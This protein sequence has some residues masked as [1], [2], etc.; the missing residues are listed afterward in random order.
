MTLGVCQPS[1]LLNTLLLSDTTDL[2]DY[3]TNLT[4]NRTRKTPT[5]YRENTYTHTL[6]MVAV[7]ANRGQELDAVSDMIDEV[8]VLKG[9]LKGDAAAFDEASKFDEGKEKETFRNYEDAKD[10]VKVSFAA[11]PPRETPRAHPS[12][13]FT[14]LPITDLFGPVFHSLFTRNSTLNSTPNKPSITT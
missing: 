13:A 3:Q 14:P 10:H 11:S 6:T 1:S 7:T 2:I 12:T 9:M 8:N 5:H 4:S